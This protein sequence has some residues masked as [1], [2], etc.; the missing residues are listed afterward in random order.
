[1]E[2][3]QNKSDLSETCVAL[4]VGP[5]VLPSVNRAVMGDW[6]GGPGAGGTGVI[7]HVRDTLLMAEQQR[8]PLG[9]IIYRE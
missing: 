6:D 8:E 5:M 1:M 9:I 4:L 2:C 7:G 3:A